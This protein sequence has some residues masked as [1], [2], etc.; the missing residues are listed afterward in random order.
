MA[1][2]LVWLTFDGNSWSPETP[3]GDADDPTDLAMVV[4]QD[5][6]NLLFSTK[7]AKKVL[8]FDEKG[9]AGQVAV[10]AETDDQRFAE[11]KS[12]TEAYQ[13]LPVTRPS[14]RKFIVASA[15]YRGAV[16]YVH[17]G[18]D[19]TG[20]LIWRTFLS[21]KWSSEYTFPNTACGPDP[22]L[23]VFA[24]VLHC[25]HRGVDGENPDN[26]RIYW[27]VSDGLGWSADRQTPFFSPA[28]ITVAAHVGKLFC[29]YV[30]S[31]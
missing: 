1:N 10:N 7:S 21:A 27:S 15:C 12:Q 4:Q 16:R 11:L 26:P 25:F 13:A 22:A 6:L 23:C 28:P 24:G 5:K 3:V 30:K 29:A 31:S 9:K 17:T 18:E 14:L 20:P 2:T 19:P 8:T